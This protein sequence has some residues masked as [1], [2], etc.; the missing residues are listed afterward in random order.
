[1]KVDAFPCIFRVLITKYRGFLLDAD[2]TLFDYDT[3]EREALTETFQEAAPHV[4]FEQALEVYRPVNAAY[5]KRFEA[6]KITLDALKVGRFVDLFAALGV[7][8]D[9]PHAAAAYLERLSR[10]AYLLPRALEAI[11][12]LRAAGPLCLVT[13]GISLVQRG[14]L[15]VSGIADRFEAVLISE[16]MGIGKPDPR[17]FQAA[18]S[19]LRLPAAELLCIGDSPHADIEG[20]RGAGI[21]ACWYNPSHAAWPGPTEPPV[22]VIDDLGSLVRIARGVYP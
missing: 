6:G 8:P 5:W 13:N 22:L 17:F 16:E 2:N 11:E 12:A 10:K 21:D 15:A 19:A 3:A 1:L 7:S 20:A 18:C 9:A 4:P 14:R